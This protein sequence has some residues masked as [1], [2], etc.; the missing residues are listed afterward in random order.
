MTAVT[1]ML[2]DAE[3]RRFARN[4]AKCPIL[5]QRVENLA[6]YF[7]VFNPSI[8]GNDQF[9]FRGHEDASWELT[10][11]ALRYKLEDD[12]TRALGLV[13]EFKRVAEIKLPRPPLPNEELKWVQLARHY[14]LPTRLLDWTESATIALYFASLNS[15]VDGIVFMLNPVDLNRMSYPK[16][17]YIF[18]AQLDEKIIA[19]YLK[20]GVRSSVRG[21]GTIA[22]NPVWNSDRLMLQKGVFT[23]HG[24]RFRLDGKQAPSLVGLPILKESKARMLVELI[25]AGVDEMSIFPELEHSC[26]FLI[27]KANLILEK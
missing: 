2:S 27:E 18:N 4:P 1:G 20:L 19:K 14:G 22:I 13:S 24:S 21:P 25:R 17:P 15:S 6:D 11:T 16:N 3:H 23:L 10:P 26:N 8:T 12:R 9:W 5:R 7:S